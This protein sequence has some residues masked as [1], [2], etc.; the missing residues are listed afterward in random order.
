MRLRS[1][2]RERAVHSSRPKSLSR[3][4]NSPEIIA[5]NLARMKDES[6]MSLPEFHH[7]LSVTWKAKDVDV[8]H[9]MIVVSTSQHDGYP[10]A[11]ASNYRVYLRECY[12]ASLASH[13][14]AYPGEKIYVRPVKAAPTEEVKRFKPDVPSVCTPFPPMELPVM[15]LPTRDKEAWTLLGVVLPEQDGWDAI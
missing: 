14:I 5:K 1:S 3:R 2:R 15:G 13:L 9:S 8:A 4:L 6:F 11:L 10:L 7:A 12:P